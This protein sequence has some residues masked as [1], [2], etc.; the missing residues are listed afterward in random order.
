MKKK[1]TIGLILLLGYALHSQD[2]IKEDVKYTR[3]I[4]KIAN[5]KE[6]KTAFQVILDLEPKTIKNQIELTEIEAPPFKEEKKALEF[7]KR[8]EKIGIDK[9]WIDS[10]GNV[11]GLIKGYEG[12]RNVAI[13]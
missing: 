6:V 8:L 9:V 11:L 1:I 3:E 2:T 10:I 7:S 5:K 12:K 13:D 4:K